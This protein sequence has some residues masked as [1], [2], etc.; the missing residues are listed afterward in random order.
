MEKDFY[1]GRILTGRVTSGVLHVGDKVHGLR[2]SDAGVQ[3][4]EEGKASLF[5]RSILKKLYIVFS[6]AICFGGLWC[7]ENRQ[8]S[9]VIGLYISYYWD[10]GN[11]DL[12]F[13]Q[14]CMEWWNLLFIAAAV[15]LLLNLTAEIWYNV[16][17][18]QQLT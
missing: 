1:L 3:K 12:R 15:Q 2:H 10:I 7:S 17:M 11:A 16:V 13:E 14:Q 5:I 4:I 18:A 8:I 6:D 9:S